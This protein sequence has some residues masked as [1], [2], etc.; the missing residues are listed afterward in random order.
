M[1]VSDA[2]IR[3]A[4]ERSLGRSVTALRR[5]RCPYGSS[6]PLEE[7]E[8]AFEE[9]DPLRLMLKD[10][11]APR[12]ARAA[13]PVGLDDSSRELA[14]YR[15]LL[16]PA[17]LDTPACYAASSNGQPWV[18]L[19]RVEGVP[20]WQ[21]GD[22]TAWEE[23]ARW[24]ALLHGTGPSALHPAPLTYDAAHLRRL[25]DRALSA[26]RDVRL[27][28]LTPR[29][30]RLVE[31]L[32]G[33]PATLVHG[34][35]YPSNVLIGRTGHGARVRPIDWEL[36]GIGPGPLDL[37]ALTSGRWTAD[38]RERLARAY[39][40]SLAPAARPDWADLRDA[41]E[42]ARLAIAVGWLGASPDWAPPAEHRH[43]WLADGLDTAA[44]LELL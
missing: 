28:R 15:D 19:E 20:L 16:G 2:D 37:A 26:R 27:E 10:L 13:K 11:A 43:D 25:L 41:L 12:A 31:R 17:G 9:G 8:V 44:R 29:W 34:D 39:H 21:V 30:E 35:F 40:A 18:L 14:A 42:H 3:G 1:P 24:L 33:W 36:I 22:F 38:E 7:L 23:A 5:R 6:H 32:A 4:L